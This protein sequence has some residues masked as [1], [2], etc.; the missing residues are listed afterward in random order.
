MSKKLTNVHL[1]VHNLLFQVKKRNFAVRQ[2]FTEILQF[3]VTSIFRFLFAGCRRHKIYCSIILLSVILLCSSICSIK[4]LQTILFTI[5]HFSI[6]SRHFTA[7]F[8]KFINF[9]SKYIL[10]NIFSPSKTSVMYFFLSLTTSN[11]IFYY[12]FRDNFLNIYCLPFI[13]SNSSVSNFNIAFS[14]FHIHIY[15]FLQII[16]YYFIYYDLY[17][18]VLSSNHQHLLIS[19]DDDFSFY[20]VD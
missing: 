6:G 19:L 13:L 11:H 5:G 15:L 18:S 16:F 2:L 14:R 4:L 20:F 8:N 1:E 12:D 3:K 10:P 9:S 17:F 7:F